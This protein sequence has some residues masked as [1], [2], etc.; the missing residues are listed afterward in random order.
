MIYRCCTLLLAFLGCLAQTAAQTHFGMPG[1]AS[2]G[3]SLQQEPVPPRLPPAYSR[4]RQ[5]PV[6][7]PG[8][9]AI[10]A[11]YQP[12]DT[13]FPVSGPP[14]GSV[15]TLPEEFPVPLMQLEGD[16]LAPDGSA[17]TERNISQF[18][19][20][21]FQ[22]ASIT[23]T[24]LVPGDPANIGVTEV[25]TLLTV[26]VPAPNK[27]MPLLISPGFRARYFD[28][29][30]GAGA[31][32][33]PAHIYDAF[34]ELRWLAKINDRV[35][36]EVGATP[37]VYSDFE[38]W[39]SDAWRIKARAGVLYQYKPDK[40]VVFGIRYLD[41]PDIDWLPVGGVIWIPTDD[42]RYE[43]VFPQSK[44]AR[45]LSYGPDWDNWCYVAIEWTGGSNS[46]ELVPGVQDQLTFRDIRARIGVERK[47]DG[48]GGF[49]LDVGYVFAR[50]YEFSGG[51]PIYEPDGTLMVQGG[52][53]Y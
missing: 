32:P 1:N 49:Q 19:E 38:Q 7:D 26:A 3:F 33:L 12:M 27:K 9:A 21:F 44:I 2:R 48:G 34:L 31:P 17:V 46:F 28:G 37:G 35:G 10:L 42:W 8:L 50:K 20:G 25:D 47:R 15:V 5:R 52:L 18:K 40:N 6:R 53:S 16:F 39:N 22:K 4:V 41:R 13:A 51:L 30:A 14:P 45:R 11:A 24:W 43:I 29:P 36:V 23:T